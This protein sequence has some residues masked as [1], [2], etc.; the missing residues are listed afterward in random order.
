MEVG[1]EW[2]LDT[3]GGP[4]PASADE[5]GSTYIMV[6]I[7]GFS[8]FVV[9]EPASDASGESVARF[10]LRLV[11]WFTRAGGPMPLAVLSVWAQAPTASGSLGP[12]ARGG[13]A[14]VGVP[15]TTNKKSPEASWGSQVSS[16][17]SQRRRP[18]SLL[19]V[20]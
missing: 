17:R 20:A 15:G 14:L 18:A 11:G 8:R 10:L 5:S 7:C 9:L 19:C 4:L 3:I 13:N 6:A 2:S 16:I 12:A 1:E